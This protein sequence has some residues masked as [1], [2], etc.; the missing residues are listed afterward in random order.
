M[1]IACLRFTIYSNSSMF[2]YFDSPN[3][4]MVNYDICCCSAW[5][6]MISATVRHGVLWYLLLF[7]MVNYDIC[8]CSAWWIM[9]SATVRHGE[10]WYLLL[11]G[12]VYYDIC[13]CSAWCIMISALSPRSKSRIS[14][15]RPG[16]PWCCNPLR[17]T[18]L[19]TRTCQ[20]LSKYLF[21]TPR[22]MILYDTKLYLS[23][24]QKCAIWTRAQICSSPDIII[25][26]ET[27]WYY[28][29]LYDIINDMPHEC[30]GNF[31]HPTEN[32]IA[33]HSWGIS[34]IISYSF[35]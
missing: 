35:V 21:W 6:I 13:Y 34:L 5:W 10:L 2:S 11:F 22:M 32:E 16:T 17:S 19:R 4:G 25:W 9:I 7:G 26:Y 3:I 30:K 31:V 27:I 15:N 23:N 29:K 12:M 8:Y 14:R 1:T 24:A 33:L 28:T 20:L 18:Q